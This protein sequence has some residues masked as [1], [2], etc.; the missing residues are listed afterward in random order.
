MKN[1][2]APIYRSGVAVGHRFKN[3]VLFDVASVNRAPMQCKYYRRRARHG[4]RAN[5]QHVATDLHL[6]LPIAAMTNT[7]PIE[8]DGNDPRIIKYRQFIAGRFL[9]LMIS[10]STVDEVTPDVPPGCAM[11]GS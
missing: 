10:T 5:E 8:H 7:V 1:I 9:T 3:R 2:S 11:L 6:D 4:T